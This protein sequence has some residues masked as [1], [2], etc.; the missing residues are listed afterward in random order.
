MHTARSSSHPG[1]LHQ[2]PP[3]DQAPQEQTPPPG[4]DNPPRSR[5][6]RDQAT[7]CEQNYR[8]L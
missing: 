8:H 2:A 6:P 3:R 7:P 5:P 1:G 4:A